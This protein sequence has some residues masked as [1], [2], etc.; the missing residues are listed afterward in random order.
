MKETHLTSFTIY[1]TVL[2]L[3]FVAL[4]LRALLVLK[5]IVADRA[6]AVG[7][8]AVFEKDVAGLAVLRL[9]EAKGR[10]VEGATTLRARDI[11]PPCLT[12]AAADTI[13]NIQWIQMVLRFMAGRAD[14]IDNNFFA[15]L[16][17][18]S[19]MPLI[20]DMFFGYFYL[21]TTWAGQG[22]I[23]IFA[24]LARIDLTHAI[25]LFSLE[26]ESSTVIDWASEVVHLRVAVV[27]CNLLPEVGLFV[28]DGL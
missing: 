14:R 2:F 4:S 18:K 24:L 16:A 26:E 19:T 21:P 9:I 6:A 27:A 3:A 10:T 1:Y 25:A 12:I 22:F 28:D 23:L 15:A 7:T 11:L 5:E 8:F 20:D 13:T 17:L